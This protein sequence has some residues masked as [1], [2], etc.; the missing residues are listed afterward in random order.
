MKINI[1]DL[2]GFIA[3]IDSIAEDDAIQGF[4]DFKKH[5]E[6]R[7]R[8][9]FDPKTM[10]CR[11]R[12]KNPEQA[13]R[14][15]DS[16]QLSEKADDLSTAHPT[17]PQ[18]AIR[19]YQRLSDAQANNGF[20]ASVSSLE[21]IETL[22]GSTEPALMKDALGKKWVVKDGG[23]DGQ[24][25]AEFEA[26]EFY[27][28]LGF[29]VPESR[30]VG[31]K[32]ISEYVDGTPLGEWI[33]TASDLQKEEVLEQLEAG[34]AA[35]AIL[36]NKDVIGLDMDNIL[37]TP[38]GKVCK[39]DNGGSLGYRAQGGIDHNFDEWP[40]ELFSM[41]NIGLGYDGKPDKVRDNI[42]MA[43][44]ELSTGDLAKAI[45]NAN[46]EQA[47]SC[48][49]GERRRIVGARVKNAREMASYA[50]DAV[51]GG[52]PKDTV[53]KLSRLCYG[54]MKTGL[55][56]DAKMLFVPGGYSHDSRFSYEIRNK[57]VDFGRDNEISYAAL[58]KAVREHGDQSC[59][60]M[61]Q[62]EDGEGVAGTSLKVLELMSLGV[63]PEEM[64]N[65]DY[66]RAEANGDRVSDHVKKQIK[67]VYDNVFDGNQ[68]YAE[69]RMQSYLLRK[70][71]TMVTL[72]N[73]KLPNMRKFGVI[74]GR[75]ETQR[76]VPENSKLG[77][78][79]SYAKDPV[80]SYSYNKLFE[81]TTGKYPKGIVEVVVPL[82]RCI[83][84]DFI[85]GASGNPYSGVEYNDIDAEF[86]ITANT[87]GLKT[88]Y[89]GNN[90]DTQR[91]TG[92]DNVMGVLA[93]VRNILTYSQ[94]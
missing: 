73:C 79:I 2:V 24:S 6:Q 71:G 20:P 23:A 81:C 51:A 90:E 36:G 91:I 89:F 65:G 87:I 35:D 46:W 86:E 14:Y 11:L 45:G 85:A 82:S 29:Y 1:K 61:Y 37:V 62:I 56:E 41:R 67:A 13:K 55:A 38:D 63:T 76:V 75:T 80:A 32:R 28:A 49:T 52:Y 18:N 9:W 44:G 4:I 66:S 27:R 40:D 26:D 39:I 10:S 3:T 17:Y 7:H 50:L 25:Q 53:E 31:G 78:I 22:P 54:L 30:M 21:F 69:E 88:F 42:G 19:N 84:A 74:L 58:D 12:Q 92:Q 33:E 94:S 8:G 93:G 59:F 16:K 5:D 60:P 70:A 83:M 15:D 47:L 57:I 72:R 68:E 48:L 64:S 43:F 77:D 34:F